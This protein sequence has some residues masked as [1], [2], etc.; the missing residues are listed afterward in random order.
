MNLG[1]LRKA[2]NG[3]PGEL[4]VEFILKDEEKTEFKLDLKSAYK[5]I[6]FDNE[7]YEVKNKIIFVTKLKPEV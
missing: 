7:N 4:E 3:F 2:T 5:H 6:D 1:Q